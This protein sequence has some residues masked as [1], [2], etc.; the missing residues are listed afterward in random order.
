MKLL[1][2]NIQYFISNKSLVNNKQ[3]S[4]YSGSEDKLNMKSSFSNKDI[5]L[6]N[7]SEK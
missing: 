7:L 2:T 6:K 5:F 4:F 3:L 1:K